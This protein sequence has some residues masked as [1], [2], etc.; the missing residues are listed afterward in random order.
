M[1]NWLENALSGI[2]LFLFAIASSNT[3]AQFAGSP[4]T[5]PVSFQYK[6]LAN[7]YKAVD[8]AFTPELY[9]GYSFDESRTRLRLE[10][11]NLGAPIYDLLYNPVYHNYLEWGNAPFYHQ[12]YRHE[13]VRFYKANAPLTEAR[14]TQGYNRGQLFRIFHTQNIHRRWNYHLHWQRLNSEGFYPHMNTERSNF[15]LSTDYLSTNGR[16]TFQGYYTWQR[17]LSNE[18][19][20]LRFDTVFTKNTRRDRPLVP[21]KFRD[22][23]ST[24]A[25]QT[26]YFQH[27]YDLLQIKSTDG[28]EKDK[29]LFSIGIGHRFRYERER[30]EYFK[31]HRDE[32]TMYFK[33][34]NYSTEQTQDSTTFEYLRN[35][36]FASVGLGEQ[37]ELRGGVGFQHSLHSSRYHKHYFPQW[38]TFGEFEWRRKRMHVQAG[39]SYLP[40]GEATGA[41]AL[42]GRFQYVLNNNL[43]LSAWI[44]NS[45][46]APHAFYRLHLSNLTGWNTSFKYIRYREAGGEIDLPYMGTLTLRSWLNEGL[47]FLDSTL[48]PFQHDG[49]VSILQAKWTFEQPLAKWLTYRHTAAMQQV[50]R[51]EL[52]RLPEWMADAEVYSRFYLFQRNLGVIVGAGAAWFSQFDAMGY[53]PVL[54]SFYL[55]E[56]KEIGNTLLVDA[57]I[58]FQIKSAVI[59]LRYENATAGWLTPYNYF[60]AKNYPMADPVLRVGLLWRF[61]N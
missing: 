31:N 54:G 50:S 11:G 33:Q 16:Y 13:Q 41:S 51:R 37:V 43:R 26:A 49:Q 59:T 32:D 3:T 58:H 4:S 10:L 29:K 45:M 46:E 35:E 40:A 30:Y 56:Q 7:G 52:I 18:N 48:K 22:G 47:I 36:A 17:Q 20:G 12:R 5:L 44:Q 57:F 27:T 9:G 25:V 61:F 15:T 55:A 60:G 28:E 24:S 42:Y 6:T 34:F 1:R 21:V 14:Y 19:G 23:K 53:S 2:A 38:R 8:T 39:I